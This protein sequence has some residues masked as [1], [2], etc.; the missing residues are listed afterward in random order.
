[1]THF[2]HGALI[3]QDVNIARVTSWLMAESMKGAPGIFVE[4]DP[5]LKKILKETMSQSDSLIKLSIGGRA[6]HG[7][8]SGGGGG[9]QALWG[10]QEGFCQGQEAQK[11]LRG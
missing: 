5:E 9:R 3:K 11:W 10:T 7:G 2:Q 6:S 4:N 1:M 8:G